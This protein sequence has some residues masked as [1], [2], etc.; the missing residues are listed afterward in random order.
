MNIVQF[1]MLQLVVH[2]LR[3]ATSCL[4]KSIKILS[5]C[6]ISSTFL[7]IHAQLNSAMIILIYVLLVGVSNYC[8]AALMVLFLMPQQPLVIM[9]HAPTAHIFWTSLEEILFNLLFL[10]KCFYPTIFLNC[11]IYNLVTF[12]TLINN[13]QMWPSDLKFFVSILLIFSDRITSGIT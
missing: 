13:Y 10:L 4:G 12:F 7:S 9:T 2:W 8:L 6:H 11:R 5:F 1:K 3:Q